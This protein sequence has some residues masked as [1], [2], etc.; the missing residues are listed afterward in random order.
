MVQWYNFITFDIVG[1]LGLGESFNCL[2]DTNL[3]PW[4]A[5]IFSHFKASTFLA[6][7]KFY[8]FLE[9]LLRRC[10]PTSLLNKQRTHYQ[11]VVE[12]IARRVNLETP[13]EDFMTNILN[14]NDNGKQEMTVEE[15]TST[16]NILIVA[17]SETTATVLSGITNYLIQNDEPLQKLKDEVRGFFKAEKD[18]TLAAVAKLPY[19]NAVIQEGLRLCPPVPAG[20]PR[21]V[22]PGGDTVCGVWLPEDVSRVHN[23]SS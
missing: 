4:V 18:I 17:G 3:H 10:I 2:Q 11:F 9:S 8:P 1:D 5:L 16:F 23:I 19:L 21:L 15:I 12:K 6:S 20:L 13:R 7:V 14:A 22:P